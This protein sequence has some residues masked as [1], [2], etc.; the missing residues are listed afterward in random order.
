MIEVEQKYRVDDVQG[1]LNRLDMHG[2][3]ETS[4][5]EEH[6]DTY[7]NH[8]SRDFAETNEAFRVRRINGA[9][10]MTYKGSKMPGLVKARREIE[11]RIGQSDDDGLAFESALELLSFRRVAT[12]KKRR[13][14][15]RINSDDGFLTI[16]IDDVETLGGFAEIEMVVDDENRVGGAR[17]SILSLATQLGLDQDEPRSYLTMLLQ[18]F[19]QA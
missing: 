2:A 15:F 1:L 14:S 10:W 5:P 7:Y 16:A 17:Q 12:V 8:P 18:R 9:A 4:E 19:E 6:A 13:R 11:L 3:T